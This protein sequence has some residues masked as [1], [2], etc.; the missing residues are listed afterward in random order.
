L[1]GEPAVHHVFVRFRVDGDALYP[2]FTA[3]ADYAYCYLA[4]VRDEDAT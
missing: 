2:E 4:A 1:V 3:G